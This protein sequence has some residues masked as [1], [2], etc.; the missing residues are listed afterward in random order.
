MMMII[1]NNEAPVFT[2]DE[3]IKLPTDCM[4]KGG[5]GVGRVEIGTKT[6][7]RCKWGNVDTDLLLAHHTD[8]FH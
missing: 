6:T 1:M 8:E 4:E 3:E 2:L 7:I 5:R